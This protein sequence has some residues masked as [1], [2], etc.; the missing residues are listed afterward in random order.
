MHDIP[1]LLV[2]LAMVL[3]AGSVVSLFFR[4]LH[5]PVVLGYVLAGLVVGPHV[6][7]PLV[8]DQENVRTLAELGII[9]L[10]F[11]IGMEFSQ[12]KLMRAG[13]SA[14]L[15][16]SM[17][18]GFTLLLGVAAVRALQ[19]STVESIFMGAA[20]CISSTMVVAKLFEEHGPTPRVR[21]AVL[22]VLV[23]QD[24]FAILLLTA[25]IAFTQVGGLQAS[26]IGRKLIHLGLTLLMVLSL[27][28]LIVPRLLRWVTDNARRETLL[29]TSAGLCF[30]FSVGAS[31]AGFSAALGAFL[32]GMLAAESGRVRAIAQLV[33]PLRDLFTTV[34]FVAVGMT[35][36]PS[37]LWSR[38]YVI[39]P[40]SILVVISNGLSLTIGGVLAGLS[41]RTSLCT[42][43]SLGQI[44]EF[45]YIILGTGVA[46]GLVHAD[47]YAIGVGVGIVTAFITPMLLKASA[48]IAE[49]VE[50]R[51]PARVRASL[52]LYHAWA[53]ALRHQGIRRGEGQSLRYPSLFLLMDSL[54]LAA[55]VIGHRL[56][57]KRWALWLEGR[58]DWG[59]ATAQILVSALL[60]GVTALMVLAIL[61]Q[62]KTLAR[63][64]ALL[65]P[66]PHGTGSGRRGRHLLAGGLRVAILLMVGLPLLALIQP[67]APRG[68]LLGTALAVF[69][70]TLA[71]Q[72]ARGQKLSRELVTGTEWLLTQAHDPWSNGG[73]PPN[74]GARTLRSLRLGNR[75]PSLGYRLSTLDLPG[76]TGVTVVA[77][78]RNGR[79]PVSLHPAPEL[80]EGDLLALAGPEQAL[81]AAEA[82]LGEPKEP[83][84]YAKSSSRV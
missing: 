59:H 28:R 6:P 36:D 49:G 53:E 11:T 25:L 43:L 48:P 71:T 80:R 66:N 76:H 31:M 39:L 81:D 63:D 79:Q 61:R 72:W 33:M 46:A 54:F 67:F 9:L 83:V 73:D 52:G 14:L 10:M 56:L 7:I 51:L 13:P 75:C 45:G 5:L 2:D 24:L 27:G 29:V 47:L 15:M 65:T 32:A 3:G 55:F 82:L 21:E 84:I 1:R 22:S 35:L 60:G 64:L 17:Q 26:Q 44:G 8:A 19:W 69:L 68:V 70:I 37:A 12:Q 42:G 16:G 74:E 23:I 34:F 78:L 20:L 58:L 62:A 18:V 50:S 30:L 38:W 57:M 40:L 77:L 4:R 41:F